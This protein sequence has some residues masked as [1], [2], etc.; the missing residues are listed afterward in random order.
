MKTLT[1][2]T[3]VTLV[4]LISL[5]TT[6]TSGKSIGP[7]SRNSHGSKQNLSSYHSK[8][9]KLNRDVNGVVELDCGLPAQVSSTQYEWFKV[10]FFKF[11]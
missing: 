10:S 3:A 11:I 8:I 7:G 9:L 6:W 4:V 1:V 5:L 2:S